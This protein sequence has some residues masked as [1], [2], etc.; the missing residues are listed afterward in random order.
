[1]VIVT[2]GSRGIGAAVAQRAAAAGYQVVVNYAT[3]H[4][5]ARAVV[6]GIEAAGGTLRTPRDWGCAGRELCPNTRSSASWPTY[7]TD[8]NS[9]STPTAPRR[10]SSAKAFSSRPVRST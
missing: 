10:C 9:R 2:G 4:D 8:G 3:G 1:M 6:A 7:S 5:A